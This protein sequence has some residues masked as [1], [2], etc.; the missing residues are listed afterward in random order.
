VVSGGT[1]DRLDVVTNAYRTRGC[2]VLH[3]ADC[4][5]VSVAIKNTNI[6]VDCWQPAAE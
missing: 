2:Q 6:A 5:A 4:G 3:T 1:R